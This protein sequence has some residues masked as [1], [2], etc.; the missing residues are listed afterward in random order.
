MPRPEVNHNLLSELNED[1]LGEYKEK[2]ERL[3]QK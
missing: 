2:L 1:D 3:L